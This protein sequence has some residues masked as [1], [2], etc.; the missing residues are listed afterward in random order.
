MSY[1]DTVS[2]LAQDAEH[3]EQYLTLMALHLHLLAW[4]GVGA[5]LIAR[6]R[7][8]ANRFSFLIKSF[9][10]PAQMRRQPAHLPAREGR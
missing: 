3:M 2:T 9:S 8:P 1:H 7:D 5:Y 10:D 4:A 6:R